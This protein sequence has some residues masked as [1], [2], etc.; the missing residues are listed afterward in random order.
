MLGL[1]SISGHL[2]E[3]GNERYKNDRKASKEGKLGSLNVNVINNITKN[4]EEG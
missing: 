4:K 3:R 1:P 2:R